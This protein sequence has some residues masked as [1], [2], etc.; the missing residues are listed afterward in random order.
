[1]NEKVDCRLKSIFLTAL[2]LLPD[3]NNPFTQ[4]QLNKNYTSFIAG[5]M[6]NKQ[7]TNQTNKTPA[8]VQRN[9][10]NKR[11]KDDNNQEM[12]EE[13]QEDNALKEVKMMSQV[14]SIRKNQG[15]EDSK[16]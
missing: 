8:S 6:I 3:S 14:F 5:G 7:P 10:G 9:F 11:S 4:S 12:N 2:S 16:R 15:K 13:L 1:M